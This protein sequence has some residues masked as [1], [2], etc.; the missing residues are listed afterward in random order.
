[1][2]N[3]LPDGYNSRSA[4]LQ[5]I[6]ELVSLF[7]AADRAFFG[8][9][10]HT[11]DD[12][13]REWL[14]PGFNLETDVHL[15]IAPDGCIVGYYEVWM[16]S[17]FVLIF[18]WGRIH[19]E[20]TNKGI[21][22]Y[23]LGWAEE[24]ARLSISQAPPDARILLMGSILAINS[25]ARQLFENNHYHYTRYSLRMVIN[26]DS[27]PLPPVWPEDIQIRTLNGE[28]DLRPVFTAAH[29]A[30]KDHWGYIERPFEEE[31][32]RWLHYQKTDKDFDPSLWFIAWDGDE[33][34]GVSICRPKV[35][36]D[37][38][39]GWVG[40]L[41]VRRPWRRRGLGLALLRHSFGELYGRGL[42]KAGLGV[43]AE[44]LSGALRLY[45][46]AGMHSD[47]NRQFIAY[48]K[49]LR[50]GTDLILRG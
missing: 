1:M 4:S 19:P 23:L 3:K 15:V 16:T 50:P 11:E 30:F 35:L 31:Y 47:P 34:A 18:C 44:N 24:R 45:E 42:R 7:N 27:P 36:D 13:H 6:P 28:N 2:L 20:H 29:E 5:D 26:L 48:E 33:I 43:D 41:S 46:K 14:S 12:T 40:S 17:P 21:G 9:D 39:M 10:K 32:Q 38:D 22:S 8:I 37:P 49:E 25:P